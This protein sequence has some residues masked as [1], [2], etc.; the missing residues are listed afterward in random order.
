MPKQPKVGLM[1]PKPKDQKKK[2]R[3]Y[4]NGKK[5]YPSIITG[6]RKGICFLCGRW[7]FTHTHHIFFGNGKKKYSGY[8]GLKAE[9]CPECHEDGKNAAHRNAETARYL[10][11]IGQQAFEEQWGSREQ[12]MKIF[13]RNYLEEEV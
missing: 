4:P 12:F 8:Y 5:E 1:F 7:G 11:K 2:R 6:N 10:Q 3:E 13:G 9:L